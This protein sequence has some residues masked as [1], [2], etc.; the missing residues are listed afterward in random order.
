MLKFE[1]TPEA[2][3]YSFENRQK[4]PS[5]K[6]FVDGLGVG[7]VGSI[8]LR[9]RKHLGQDGLIIIVAA[10]DIVDGYIV[11]GPDVV[12]RG[13]VYVRESE[14]II[15]EVRRIATEILQDFALKNIN[16]WNMIKNKIKEE[17]SK[18]IFTKTRRTPMILPIIMEV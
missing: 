12:S 17:V 9:D 1:K 16:E 15:H 8:V 5:G 18:H 2:C 3:A 13:F 7:D 10:L 4:K 14:E 11:S 6:I